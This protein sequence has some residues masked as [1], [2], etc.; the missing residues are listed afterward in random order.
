[1]PTLQEIKSRIRSVKSTRQITKAMEMVAAAKLRRA[2]AGATQ[3][4]PYAN[5]MS[6]MLKSLAEAS[7]GDISHP[8]FEER[9]IK[10]RTLVLVTS[11]K[12][13]CGSFNTNLIRK[14]QHWLDQFSPSEVDLVLIGRRGADYFRRREFQIVANYHDWGGQL[15]YTTARQIVAFLTGRFMAKETDSIH[16]IYPRFV[17]ISVSK[18]TNDTYLPIKKPAQESVQAGSAKQYIFEPGPKEIYSELMSSY[19][20]TT[21]VTVLLDSFASEHGSRMIAMGAATKNAGELID[22]L[23][24]TYNKARQTKIT[25]ELLEIVSGAEALKA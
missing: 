2:Q 23:S 16:L 10:K 17:S 11:D 8:Y 13:L 5:S 24:L 18:I 14:A 9:E 1:M 20:L 3:A 4:R 12:G 19:V 25:T 21:M 15:N 6:A 7:T 22:N